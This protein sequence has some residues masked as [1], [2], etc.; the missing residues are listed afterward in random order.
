MTDTPNRDPDPTRRSPLRWLLLAGL[1]ALLVVAVFGVW[2]LG[3]AGMLPGQ[4]EATRIPVTP[5]ANI[6]GFDSF[7]TPPPLAS[8]AP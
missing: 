3:E 5:F 8:P 1:V 7:P 4:P 2:A 6:P